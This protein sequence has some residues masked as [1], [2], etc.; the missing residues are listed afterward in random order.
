MVNEKFILDHVTM[1]DVGLK[2]DNDNTFRRTVDIK[3][4]KVVNYSEWDYQ[5]QLFIKNLPA[6][7]VMEIFIYKLI[8][9]YGLNT[10]GIDE[11]YINKAG[12]IIEVKNLEFEL[13]NFKKIKIITPSLTEDF[14][15]R[16]GENISK[17][18]KT[19]LL[20]QHKNDIIDHIIIYP[21]NIIS[22][23][24]YYDE[25]KSEKKKNLFSFFNYK[26]NEPGS[27]FME[28]EGLIDD[29]VSGFL[30]NNSK[31]IERYIKRDNVFILMFAGD[32]TI[33]I[34]DMEYV[35]S[36]KNLFEPLQDILID[37]NINKEK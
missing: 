10:I 25:I 28:I 26:N 21:S 1:V 37:K 13:G 11:H 3:L 36:R 23:V 9:T 19:N 29:V 30:R 33:E 6:K 27:E 17:N 15:Q 18:R 2:I 7:E 16:L 34:R 8:E 32:K 12:K 20:N 35:N 22:E 5:Y 14:I 24:M 4:D 31:N